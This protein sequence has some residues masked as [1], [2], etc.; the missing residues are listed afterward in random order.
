MTAIVGVLNRRGVAFAADSAAT[1]TSKSGQKITNDTNKIFALSKYNPVGIAIYNN[2]DFMGIPWET[3]IKMY[4]DNLNDTKFD[5]L[6]EY[7]SSF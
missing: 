2:L 7:V 4:R 6:Q 5:T 3:I 1:H